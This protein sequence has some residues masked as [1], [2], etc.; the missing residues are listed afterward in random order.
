MFC[1]VKCAFFLQ[2]H[3]DEMQILVLYVF[4]MQIELSVLLVLILHDS[5]LIP[6]KKQQKTK[7]NANTIQQ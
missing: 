4:P 3:H 6:P 5:Y 7:E 2:H 1:L